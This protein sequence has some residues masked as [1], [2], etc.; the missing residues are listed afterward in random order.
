M[1]A[2]AGE[3][4]PRPAG[5]APRIALVA[6]EASGDLLGAG[7]IRE[8]R[9]R[10]PQAQ[11]AGVGGERMRDAGFDAWW[12][13]ESLAVMGLAEV[14][15]HLPR[16]LR[17]RG[18]LRRRLLDWQPQVFVGIDAPD[19]N[20][21]LERALSSRGVATV[22]YVSPSVWAWRAGRAARIGRSARRVLC[23]FPM[24]PAIYARHGVDAVFVGHPLADRMPLAT[25]REGARARLGIGLDARVLAILPGSRG[26]E[27]ERLAPVFLDAAS[28]LLAHH[29]DLVLVAPMAHARGRAHF[30][31]CL[32]EASG[33]H[34]EIA[35]LRSAGRLLIVEDRT[36][37]ALSAADAAVLASGTAALEAMLAK[38]PTVIGYVVA[39]LTAFLV[40]AFDLIRSPYYAL[41]N[42]LANAPLMPELLQ[43]LCTAPRIAEALDASLRI[44]ATARAEYVARCTEIHAS[45][46]RDADASAAEAVADVLDRAMPSQ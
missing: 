35:A 10:Y 32:D 40:R 18:D 3:A 25:D 4:R 43:E 42:V 37:D 39:P 9:S 8:L 6:G 38:V 45:L 5:A 21:R 31:R 15:A 14:L 33:R 46:R 12:P 16:L 2:R 44:E 11:F 17:L 22:H 34:A 23:L 29:P 28:L 7:L 26:S 20:L 1:P 41:P 24:E 19:F 13:S 30:E 27:I 36:A